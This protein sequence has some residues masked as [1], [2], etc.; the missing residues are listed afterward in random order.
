MRQ[1]S[2]ARLYAAHLDATSAVVL[3]STA[4]VDAALEAGGEDLVGAAG[5][6]AR[7]LKAQRALL[8]A[9]EHCI[10]AV[11]DVWESTGNVLPAAGL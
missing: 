4:A 6:H 1:R 3:R 5:V 7:A 2:A 10:D 11:I 8:E 9:R